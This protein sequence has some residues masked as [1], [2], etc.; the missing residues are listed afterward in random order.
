MLAYNVSSTAIKVHW[1]S[2]PVH[3]QHGLVL[4]YH[5]IV[6]LN[7]VLESKITVPQNMSE[8]VVTNLQKYTT[9]Q[10]SLYG[11]T[12]KGSGVQ[13]TPISVSTDEDGNYF[14]LYPIP[15]LKTG[16]L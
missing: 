14:V 4:G 12:V 2:I 7:S 1:E 10:V 11:F 6:M 8:M 15:D 16:A 3:L 13:S 9:Y 5:L